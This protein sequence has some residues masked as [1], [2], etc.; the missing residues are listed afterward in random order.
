MTDWIP[1]RC[2]YCGERAELDVDDDGWSSQSYVQDCPVC[3]QPWQVRLARDED[4]DWKA[5]LL[6]GDE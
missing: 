4:G 1:V 5:T 2:P 6:T 3:C